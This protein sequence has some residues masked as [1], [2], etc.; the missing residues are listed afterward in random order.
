MSLAFNDFIHISDHLDGEGVAKFLIASNFVEVLRQHW[1]SMGSNTA[2]SWR[3]ATVP[4]K[5]HDGAYKVLKWNSFSCAGQQWSMV[6]GQ[7]I[8]HIV[9]S[10][11]MDQTT[12][13]NGIV[14]LI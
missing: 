6:C 4:E 9:S 8:L 7:N 1:N 12:L 13:D 11:D 5:I 3:I 14:I 2:H 10:F